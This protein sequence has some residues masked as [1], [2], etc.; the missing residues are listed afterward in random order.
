MTK[1]AA[2]LIAASLTCLTLGSVLAL[3][4]GSE[5]SAG[6]DPADWAAV[7]F[8]VFQAALS[9][10]V[11]TGL[12]V[13]LARALY[14]R[15]FWGKGVVITVMGAPFVLP[16]L[17]AVLGLLTIF[18][19]RGPVNAGLIALGLPEF[20]VFGLHGVVL[21]HVFLNLPLATRMILI[22]WQGIPAER[23]RLAAS[24]DLS[25]GAQ[26]RH[27]EGPM[28]IR[29]L[30]GAALA[31]F[32]ICLTSFAVA[33]TLGGG[34]GATT[35]ELLIY[36]SLRY[37]FDLG[38]AAKFA[39]VQFALSGAATLAA[40]WLVPASLQDAGKG[41]RAAVVAPSG[42]RR[43]ADAGTITLACLFLTL[44]LLA[45]VIRGIP[46]L[47]SLPNGLWSAAGRSMVVAVASAILTAG[48]TL[49][50]SVAMARRAP[51][52]VE[53][54]S[55]LPLASS[56]LVM[57]TALFLITRPLSPDA[58]AL[59]VTLLTNVTL[60]LPFALRLVLPH[61]RRVQADYGR[62]A[63]SLGMRG[64]GQMRHLT[65]PRLA[66]PLA[67]AAGLSAAMSM[68]DLGVIA[69]F[70]GEASQTLPLMISRLTSAYRI[71]AAAA[72]SLVLVA[73]SLALFWAIDRL[74]A[75]DVDA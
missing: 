73:L 25:P 9:A 20:S 65:L 50:L 12:A 30:P 40:I 61:A 18:G 52:W 44:P 7:R 49:I 41:W 32:L 66:R 22:G 48:M 3:W 27:V 46:G 11:S 5:R 14:R 28:L 60:T 54:A 29:V 39:L 42:W 6:L 68:G 4:L 38:Q 67:F 43:W 57:G 58:L 62:L 70:S 16:V 53:V 71:E 56:S 64:W 23:F 13:P 45:V 69:L 34:P 36:Q 51:I 63:A 10:L 37:E 2:H 72:A 26:F 74:G 1:A 55:M 8:T 31:V 24:L 33:L 47:D 21:A 35:V 19:P 59:P 75:R 17:V 15:H